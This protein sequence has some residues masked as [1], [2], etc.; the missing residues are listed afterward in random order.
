MDS[1]RQA[2]AARIIHESTCWICKWSTYEVDRN[3]ALLGFMNCDVGRDL[4]FKWEDSLGASVV[5]G[6]PR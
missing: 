5:V 2:S 6:E 1:I 4:Y 3:G